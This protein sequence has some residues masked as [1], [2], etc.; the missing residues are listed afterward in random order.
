MKDLAS[1]SALV[2]NQLRIFIVE[3][4]RRR[5]RP[6]PAQSLGRNTIDPPSPSTE[7]GGRPRDLQKT[8]TTPAGRARPSPLSRHARAACA[9][10]S[11]LCVHTLQT[12][13]FFIFGRYTRSRCTSFFH[14]DDGSLF[15]MLRHHFRA[16]G[17]CYLVA[18]S[19]HPIEPNRRCSRQRPEQRPS[20]E[21]HAKRTTPEGHEPIIFPSGGLPAG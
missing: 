19:K 3:K 1:I 13:F 9:K 10:L 5:G 20:T 11:D 21:K 12:T 8:T 18:A 2:Y 15:H 7:R 17:A 16:D 4:K 6:C 14:Q